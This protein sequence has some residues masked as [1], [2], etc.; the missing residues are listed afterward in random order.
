MFSR[1][2]YLVLAAG[3]LVMPL[4]G[5]AAIMSPLLCKGDVRSH[6]MHSSGAHDHSAQQ[7]DGHGHDGTGNNLE[8][9]PCFS[10]VSAP[11]PATLI[12]TAASTYPDRVFAPDTE[13]DPFIPEQPHRP[14]LV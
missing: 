3:L 11:L 4:H 2:K 8:F 5:V 9:H 13:Y 10:T 1:L 12:L 6:V 14:P 7:D